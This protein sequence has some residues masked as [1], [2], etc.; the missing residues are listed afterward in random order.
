M[1]ASKSC[2]D[3]GLSSPVS[4]LAASVILAVG[5]RTTPNSVVT[6]TSP[7]VTEV[8]SPLITEPSV[9]EILTGAAFRRPASNVKRQN[10]GI[11]DFMGGTEDVERYGWSFSANRQNYTAEQQQ[12]IQGVKTGCRANF[13]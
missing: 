10:N 4:F 3:A 5:T 9:N 6:T 12:Y 11:I 7:D 8:I 2:C 1:R 13:L